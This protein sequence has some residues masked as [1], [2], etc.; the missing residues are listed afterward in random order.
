[1][2]SQPSWV[3]QTVASA[4]TVLPCCSPACSSC[5]AEITQS[6]STEVFLALLGNDCNWIE[7]HFLWIWLTWIEANRNQGTCC[8]LSDITWVWSHV[9]L[10]TSSQA[11]E[12]W[13]CACRDVFPPILIICKWL[14]GVARIRLWPPNST[15]VCGCMGLTCVQIAASLQCFCIPVEEEEEEE[16]GSNAVWCGQR[17]W[18]SLFLSDGQACSTPHSAHLSQLGLTGS[19]ASGRL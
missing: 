5:F 14:P 2:V 9:A 19:L 8:D 7:V 15:A 6:N 16:G 18:W 1:M 17:R 4:E 13:T 11:L 10:I 12:K 3:S